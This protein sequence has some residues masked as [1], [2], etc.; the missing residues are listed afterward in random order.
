MGIVFYKPAKYK[1]IRKFLV[2]KGFTIREGG[3]H[4][5]ATHPEDESVE[6]SVPRH[7][8]LSNGVTNEICKK[9]IKLGYPEAEVEKL[10]N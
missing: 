10:L 4:L 2:K 7:K 6:I 3:E 1:K 5:I 8:T 9:L